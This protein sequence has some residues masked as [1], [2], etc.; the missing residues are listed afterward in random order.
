M[1][2]DDIINNDIIN[3]DIIDNDIIVPKGLPVDDASVVKEE[4]GEDDLGRVKPCSV[5]VEL[6]GSLNLEHEVTS[7]DVFHHKEQPLLDGEMRGQRST[8]NRAAKYIKVF[9]GCR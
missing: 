4:K 1:I 2:N 3:N 5:L 8:Q 6:A 7:I 9:T